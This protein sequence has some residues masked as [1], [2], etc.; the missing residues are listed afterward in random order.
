V[1]QV[2]GVFHER[3]C[4]LGPTVSA[5]VRAS[6]RPGGRCVEVAALPDNSHAVRDSKDPD[7][8]C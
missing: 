8:P 4:L 2:V 5:T 3:G 7:G 6:A 1:S